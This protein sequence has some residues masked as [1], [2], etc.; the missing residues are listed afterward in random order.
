MAFPLIILEKCF[1]FYPSYNS[2]LLIAGHWRYFKGLGIIRLVFLSRL[3]A[4]RRTPAILR[5]LT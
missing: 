1:S 2:P 3:F 5:F 4:R